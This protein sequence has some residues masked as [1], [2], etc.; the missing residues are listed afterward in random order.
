MLAGLAGG[1]GTTAIQEI[2]YFQ[3]NRVI[4]KAGKLK[5]RQ[6]HTVAFETAEYLTRVRWVKSDKQP[7]PRLSSR[8][9]ETEG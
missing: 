7:E 5:R 8:R 1:V 4:P 2:N 6:F 9:E 3:A